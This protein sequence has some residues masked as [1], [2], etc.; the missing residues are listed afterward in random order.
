MSR[1]KVWD[2]VLVGTGPGAAAW[3]KTTM[4]RTGGQTSVL[5]IE[6]GPY[7]KT[8]ILT[9]MNPIEALRASR[10]MVK[11]YE[12]EV[13]QGSCL[14]G[15]TGVN[16]YAWVTPA[17]KDVRTSYGDES[18]NADDMNLSEYEALVEK[19]AFKSP[20]HPLHEMMTKNAEACALDVHAHHKTRVLESNRG[21]V[22][23]GCPSIDGD[24]HRRSAFSAV[25]EPLLREYHGRIHLKTDCEVSNVILDGPENVAVG[26]EDF[27][28]ERYMADRVVLG[29]GCL[30]T[31]A[32]LMR[33]G[34][35]PADH[36]RMRDIEVS[37]DNPEVGANLG[38]KMLTDDMVITNSSLGDF[39]KSLFLMNAVFDDGVCVQLHRYDKFTFGNSYLAMSR[40]IRGNGVLNA[41][42]WRNIFKYCTPN[43]VFC[44]Q[45]MYK[46]N[47]TATVRLGE[48]KRASLD[49]RALF[50]EAR[51]NKAFYEK[52][53]DEIYSAVETMKDEDLS[54]TFC[55]PD[56]RRDPSK[57]MRLVWHFAGSCSAGKVVQ[58]TD[59]S[60]LG[61]SGLHIVD[62]SVNRR[63]PDGG[64]QPMA[65]L[66][67]FLA[68]EA[69]HR[70][71]G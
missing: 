66:T 13:M 15:G 21:A 46:M 69:M 51:S 11:E 34:I 56:V 23:L 12:H 57:H 58:I 30:E 63:P 28:G 41:T 45:T 27:Q 52:R 61:T 48:D 19:I 14:G 20:L 39:D 70:R 16:N 37:H 3:L 53:I 24:G 54:Y 10:T 6:R 49:A 31:P 26:V 47:K 9:E 35:G 17:M 50:D 5:I 43:N 60:V 7:C 29:A 40:L 2:Y 62:N 18:L 25:I 59:F 1:R 65:Y 4:Q 44:F 68:A 8:D 32:I 22:H 33:S 64:G 36:L 38:D 71:A 42:T 67:G 55:V